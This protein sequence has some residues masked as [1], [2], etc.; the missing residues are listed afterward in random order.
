[1]KGSDNNIDKCSHVKSP[2]QKQ[3][4]NQCKYL[5]E[6]GTT[7]VP[8]VREVVEGRADKFLVIFRNQTLTE[9]TAPQMLSKRV[10]K[11]P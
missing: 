6:A 4:T 5:P 3:N 10:I 2:K 9:P 7:E 1:M 11:R 8:V